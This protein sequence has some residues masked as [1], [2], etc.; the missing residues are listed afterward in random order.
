MSVSYDIP[1]SDRFL[2]FSEPAD[3]HRGTHGLCAAECG[4]KCGQKFPEELPEL[5]LTFVAHDLEV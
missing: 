4:Q 1:P 2:G 5:F 3:G